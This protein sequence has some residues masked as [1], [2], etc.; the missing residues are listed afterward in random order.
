MD[1]QTPDKHKHRNLPDLATAIGDFRSFSNLSTVV[2]DLND[3]LQTQNSSVEVI[4]SLYTNLCK[5][6][7]NYLLGLT[8]LRIWKK[9]IT[10]SSESNKYQEILDAIDPYLE[11]ATQ[12][13]PTLPALR[14]LSNLVIEHFS[15]LPPSEAPKGVDLKSIDKLINRDITLLMEYLPDLNGE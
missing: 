4:I 5:I 12:V 14:D 8:K 1:N 13:N 9:S 10:G 2:E 11:I 7:H 6:T 15:A 3:R